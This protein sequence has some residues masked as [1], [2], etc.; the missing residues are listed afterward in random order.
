[1]NLHRYP[2]LIDRL[3]GEY[4]LGVLRGAA[5]RR[6]ARLAERDPVVRA[7]IEA[8]QAR[9][10]AMTELA[11][12]VAPPPSTWEA[13]ERRLGLAAPRDEPRTAAGAT[14]AGAAARAERRGARWFE[15]LSF[16]RGWSIGATGAALAAAIALAVTLRPFAGQTSPARPEQ[17]AEHAPPPSTRGGAAI[18][19]VSYVAA[20]ADVQTK[21]TMVLVMWDDKKAMLSVHRMAGGDAAP[22]GKSEELWGIREDGRKVSL[23][24]LPPGKIV[25]M[26]MHGMNAF[27]KLA[28]SVE[29]EGGSPSADGPSGPVVC[30]GKLMATA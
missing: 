17:V 13:L 10:D 23:G 19:N 3:A 21:K 9:I 1:M 5:R 6:F 26:K 27:V 30:A 4:A 20:L 2:D 24:M 7:A 28:V 12:P 25:T 18:E 22:A 11:R 14:L 16:W 8:W 15:S 29:P